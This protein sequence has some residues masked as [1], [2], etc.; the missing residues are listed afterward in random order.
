MGVPPNHPTLIGCF[1]IN[2][3]IWGIPILG[4]PP[5]TYARD[6]CSPQ[7]PRVARKAERSARPCCHCFVRGHVHSCR[8]VG[9]WN[10]AK[11]MAHLIPNP[12]VFQHVDPNFPKGS[13]IFWGDVLFFF[14][15]VT[16]SPVFRRKCGFGRADHIVSYICIYIYVVSIYI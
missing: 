8:C 10:F 6:R 14:S 16:N 9:R 11:N 15:M 2:N 1:I 13:H 5:C 7:N 12:M 4:N 3:S